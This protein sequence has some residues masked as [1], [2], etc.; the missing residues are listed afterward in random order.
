MECDAQL[1][2]NGR[3]LLAQ[4]VRGKTFAD[5]EADPLLRSGVERHIPR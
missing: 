2:T 5:Y 4:F 3:R 1:T